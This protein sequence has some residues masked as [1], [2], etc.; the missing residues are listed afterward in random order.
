MSLP[1]TQKAYTC[2]SPG[3]GHVQVKPLPILDNTGILIKIKAVALNPTDWKHLDKMLSPG[4]SMGAD[5]A[6]D[7]VALGK[8]AEGKGVK[9]GDAVAGYVRGGYAFGDKDNAAFQEYIRIYPELVWH[10]PA[11][12]SYEAAAALS[13]AAA[14]AQQALFVH[15]GVPKPWSGQTGGSPILIWS[16][17]TSVGDA[18]IQIAAASGL[19]VISTA[20][21]SN[22]DYLKSLGAAEVFDYKDPEVVD[23]IK[24]ASGGGV[25]WALDTISEKG[26]TV[27]AAECFGSERGKVGT[28]LPVKPEDYPSWPSSVTPERTLVYSALESSNTTD[29]EGLKDWYAH[30]PGL[31]EEG[32]IKPQPLKK[33]EGGMEALGEALDYLK[34]GKVR[35]EKVVLSFE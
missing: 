21:P 33:F 34:S 11:S 8:E 1:Q 26:S 6:G 22:H 4:Q 20:S 27:L 14:T 12:L 24:Q 25:K 29:Y 3:V 17:A 30:L 15:L 19:K 23:K 28:L 31:V 5:F 2:L 16:G 7:V 35:R 9:V 10:K 18:A 13:L 32:K